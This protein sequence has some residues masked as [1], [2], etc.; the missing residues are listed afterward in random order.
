MATTGVDF[1]SYADFQDAKG[2]ARPRGARAGSGLLRIAVRGKAHLLEWGMRCIITKVFAPD[3]F[4]AYQWQLSRVAGEHGGTRT[5]YF[6]DIV[7]R[8]KAGV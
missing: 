7:L 1:A 4:L 8:Q 6:Y 2:P 3:V 5:A